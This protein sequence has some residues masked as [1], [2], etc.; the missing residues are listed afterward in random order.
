MSKEGKTFL[1][2]KYERGKDYW[3]PQFISKSRGEESETKSMRRDSGGGR[4]AEVR[5][6]S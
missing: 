4:K 1:E 5:A 6:G 2:G 3:M